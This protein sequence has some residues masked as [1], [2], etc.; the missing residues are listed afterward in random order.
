MN[1]SVHRSLFGGKLRW[2]LVA[3]A[4]IL[5]SLLW[6]FGP[7]QDAE[8][9]NAADMADSNS[10]SMMV[11]VWTAGDIPAPDQTLRFRGVI[12]PKRSSELSFR[13]NGR[14]ES[15]NVN[16]GDRV[17]KGEVLASL[18]MT[19]L[20]VEYARAIADRDSAAAALAEAIAGPRQQTI[21]VASAS[22]RRAEADA[23][24]ATRRLKRQLD[25]DQSGSASD[26]A[27][28]DARFA[29]ESAVAAVESSRATL[30]ELREGTRKE[31]IDAA[32]A[33]VGSAEAELAKIAAD[34]TDSQLLAPFD[35]IVESRNADEGVIAGGMLGGGMEPVL[36]IF[37]VPPYEARFGIPLAVAASIDVGETVQVQIDGD[38]QS[39]VSG[40]IIRLHPSVDLV[41]RNRSIDVQ[42]VDNGVDSDGC[43]VGQTVQLIVASPQQ[44]DGVWVP[45]SAMVRGVRGL[46]S[47]YVAVPMID[48]QT[49]LNDTARTEFQAII[50]RRNVRVIST[51]GPMT[52][53]DGS[54][55][56]SD[57]IIPSGTQ[58][59]A[60]GATVS[61]RIEEPVVAPEMRS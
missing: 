18:D 50:E 27:V 47:I 35:C 15:I 4:I 60:P 6:Q 33:A 39:F 26:Q 31:I 24:L 25:L 36:R 28:D 5:A 21:D 46:W 1:K 58:R 55:A 43:I 40:Q 30:D 19:D 37:E 51:D 34:R 41:T 2:A 20:D 52:K 48:D 32:R 54:V 59:V 17:S 11:A 3:T 12:R 22:L 23:S 13:R 16:E 29:A 45:T 53:I 57:W 38:G 44:T 7:S 49:S 8:V 14:I 61:V 42:L 9:P 56:K 10:T